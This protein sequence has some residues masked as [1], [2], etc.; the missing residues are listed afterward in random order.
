MRLVTLRQLR[1]LNPVAAQVKKKLGKNYGIAS[2]A[3]AQP[4][5]FKKDGISSVIFTKNEKDIHGLKKD[6]FYL[7]IDNSLLRVDRDVENKNVWIVVNSKIGNIKYN[8]E[9]VMKTKRVVEESLE[10]RGLGYLRESHG[11]ERTNNKYT[12]YKIDYKK[13]NQVN[14]AIYKG[15]KRQIIFYHQ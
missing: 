11:D 12:L 1:Y 6:V 3:T 15:G 13:G 10:S 7:T 14:Y 2:F 8:P 5:R 9:T 4:G